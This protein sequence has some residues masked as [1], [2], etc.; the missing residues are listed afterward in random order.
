MQEDYH[1]E[2]NYNK[3]VQPAPLG[4]GQ[5]AAVVILAIFAIFAVVMWGRQFKK[6]INGPFAY[7][8]PNETENSAATQNNSDEELKNKDTDL[9]GL[10][11]WDELNLYKTS[12][13]LEDSDS[14]GFSD[15]NEIDSGNDPNCPTGRDCYGTTDPLQNN[16]AEDNPASQENSATTGLNLQLPSNGQEEVQ[17]GGQAQNSLGETP[18]AASLRQMLLDAGMDE[19]ILKQFSDEDLLAEWQKTFSGAA[20]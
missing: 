18:D 13:Y 14:D 4:K 3:S 2:E 1:N 15:K 8:A 9:D 17:A 16:A 20:Q 6:S 11:D 7:N 12:P 5:K 10:S 19:K